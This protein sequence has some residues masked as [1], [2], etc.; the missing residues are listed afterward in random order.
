LPEYITSSL[1]ES[2]RDFDEWMPGFYY[3]DAIL[4]GPET[5]T[6]SPIRM[7]RN[8]QSKEALAHP[9]IYPSG[10]G[11]GYAGGIISAAVDGI[12]CAEKIINKQ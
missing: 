12:K 1:A 11:A 5:R 10:E 4:T 8:E 7:L 2:F 6:T 9:H 3:P